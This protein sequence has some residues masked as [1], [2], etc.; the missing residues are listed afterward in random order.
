MARK[1]NISL[2]RG[3]PAVCQRPAPKRLKTPIF[4]G[5]GLTSEA[6]NKRSVPLAAV[7]LA[8]GMGTRMKSDVPKVL[9]A[10]AGEPILGHILRIL[11]ALG[12][13]RLAVV[14]GA[15]QSNV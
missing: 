11:K 8:A 4:S 6:L 3:P 10:V 15:R 5:L 7:V 1:R 12:A 9:H 13:A 14:V 2:F